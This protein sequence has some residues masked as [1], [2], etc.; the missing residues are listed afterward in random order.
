MLKENSP[1]KEADSKVQFLIGVSDE[2]EDKIV[3]QRE[4]I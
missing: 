4:I 1:K 2:Y 3:I